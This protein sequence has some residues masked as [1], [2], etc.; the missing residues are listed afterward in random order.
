M[1][2]QMLAMVEEHSVPETQADVE[3]VSLQLE[4]PD[5]YVTADVFCL[6]DC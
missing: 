4:S 6:T 2:K 1:H 3:S 5:V